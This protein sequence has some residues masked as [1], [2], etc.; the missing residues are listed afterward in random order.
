MDTIGII[1]GSESLAV[2]RGDVIELT[3]DLELANAP[4]LLAQLRRGPGEPIASGPDWLAW[5]P[6]GERT[7]IDIERTSSGLRFTAD[8]EPGLYVI[9]LFVG[10]EPWGDASYGLLLEVE[11]AGP[12]PLSSAI[13]LGEPTE[14]AVGQTLAIEGGADTL[15]LAGVP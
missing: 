3:S 15:T 6:T 11:G 7:L 10:I 12:T 9:S 4:Q 1:T 13:A 5:S 2:K 8:F 14:I